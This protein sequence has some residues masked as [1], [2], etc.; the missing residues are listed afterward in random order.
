[1]KK[2]A[3]AVFAGITF[4]S[5]VTALVG[6]SNIVVAAAAFKD[7][8]SNHWAKASID[9]AVNKGYLKGY[10]DGTFRP[11]A[12]VTRAEF[13]AILSRIS[14]NQVVDGKGSFA[15]LKG[16]WSEQ[17]V[18]K[19]L[20]MG[21]M[22]PSDYP[23]GFKPSTQLTRREMAKWMA[24]GLAS[25]QEDFHKALEDTKDT[26][27]PVAEYYKGGLDKV[28]YPYVSVALGTGLMN[29]YEDGS[30]GT[31]KTTT[32]A[33]VAAILSRY[34]EV[35]KKEASSFRDLNEMREVGLTG[36][37]LTSATDYEYVTIKATG[38][39]AD[40]N[41][42]RDQ[43]FKLR[44]N[45]GTQILHRMI[46]VDATT[47]KKPKNL[48][49]KMFI[50]EKYSRVINSDRYIVFLEATVI[51]DGDNLD[52][53]SFTNATGSHF[54]SARN[55]SS[56]TAKKYRINALPQDDFATSGFFKMGKSQRFW[57][58][59]TIGRNYDS[60]RGSE[61]IYVNDKVSLFYAPK[62]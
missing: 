49:G 45:L 15:D 7:V 35:Q 36:T 17:E 56:G 24:S 12:P 22:S 58:Q 10:S 42:V 25:A 16:N 2:L 61:E 38:V 11:N 20:G 4:I 21:F 37:N 30:F 32:R 41:Q 54:L 62:K 9:A 47:D 31:A 23:G 50:D 33:E 29:G 8:S 40:F 44:N 53:L 28:D 14:T 48:Y 1:M 6:T 60:T 3:L 39:V 43:A 59:T 18:T 13:A 5:A 55:F 46:V 27:V 51:P 57:M 52:N 19:A 34:E 26:L